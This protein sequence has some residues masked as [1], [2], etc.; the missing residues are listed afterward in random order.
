MTA[1]PP[2]RPPAPLDAVIPA[3]PSK[4]ETHRVLIAAALAR[5]EST[6]EAP[7]VADDTR[8]T[9]DGLAALGVEVRVESARWHVRGTAGRLPGGARLWMGGSGT[10]LRLL[11]AVAAMGER[12]S[13][14]DG[15]PRLRERPLGELVVALREL[16][17]VADVRGVGGQLPLVAGGRLPRGGTVTLRAERSSQFASALLLIAPRLALGLDL[18]L[19]PPAVSLPYVDMT[20]ATL[21]EFGVDVARP[22]EWQFRVRPTE[23]A[24]RR[25]RVGGDH[26]AAS[27]FLAA[28]AVATGRVRVEGLDPASAQ[29]DA[30][31]AALLERAGCTVLRGDHWV[32]V[33]ADRR[34]RALDVDLGDCPDLVPTVAVLMMFAEGPS[35][36]RGVAH[37]RHKESDRLSVLEHNLR[38]FGCPARARRDRLEIHPSGAELHGGVVRTASDHRIA[39]AFAVAALRVPGVEFD[40][41]DCVTK[42]NPDF[43]SAWSALGSIANRTSPG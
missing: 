22:G 12:A 5:G 9:L 27:Y 37:L 36:L 26:S 32:E 16:G 38:T 18:H 34:P 39:M 33:R 7:L 23:F 28:A 29:P 15:T 25:L 20:I 35:C 19:L 10:S 8:A 17:A 40:D 2:A 43:W 11:S 3:V 31:F 6:I 1:T 13:T 21:R 42:S 14:L 41:A 4:S 24:G 30:R